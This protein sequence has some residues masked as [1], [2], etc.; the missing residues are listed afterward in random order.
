MDI[1]HKIKKGLLYFAGRFL[2]SDEKRNKWLFEKY[3]SFTMIDESSYAANLEIARKSRKISGDVV[4]CGVWRGGM[5]AGIAELL[6]TEKNY[7]LYDSF[8]GLPEAK[9]ID[10]KGAIDWQKN[11][12]GDF[13]FDNCKAEIEFAEKAMNQTGAK[14]S[15]YKGWFCDTLPKNQITHISLLRLDG[16]WYDS[17][18][19]CL[20]HLFPK[21]VKGGVVLIDDY[22]TWDGCSRAVHDYLSSVQSTSRVSSHKGVA[23]IIK[24][25]S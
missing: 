5:I 20:K 13:Y 15:C 24:N 11:T 10:G 23:Y 2:S 12:S 6:G 25:D 14:Y 19:D 7:H 18:M 22:H 16:D 4:E 1:S 21:V 3:R 17:T 8:E 9:E